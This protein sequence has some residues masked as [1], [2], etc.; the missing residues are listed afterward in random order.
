[1]PEKTDGHGWWQV[2][3]ATGG[4]TAFDA[5]GVLIPAEECAEPTVR[6]DGAE[7]KVDPPRRLPPGSAV[8]EIKGDQY[9]LVRMPDA[10][11]FRPLLDDRGPGAELRYV[12]TKAFW[13]WM[14]VFTV[15]YYRELAERYFPPDYLVMP[16]GLLPRDA[17]VGATPA[18]L[19]G[20]PILEHE[21]AAVPS[22]AF[23][24]RAIRAVAA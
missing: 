1:M 15:E 2:D 16:L 8:V 11:P 7:I 23:R 3:P 14:E 18:T 20:L 12:P 4:L 21:A 6:L 17:I 24:R 10:G 13:R 19:M 22:L 9:E 5:D